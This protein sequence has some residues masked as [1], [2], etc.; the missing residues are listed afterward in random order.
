MTAEEN[1]MAFLKSSEILYT[2][3]NKTTNLLSAIGFSMP[4]TCNHSGFIG[5]ITYDGTK[6]NIEG[7]SF[8]EVF[9][10]GEK[11]SEQY[12]DRDSEGTQ[13]SEGQQEYFKDSKVRDENGNL[14]IMY[15]GTAND[16]TVFNPML[17]GGKMVRKKAMESI[18]LI[19]PVERY[20]IFSGSFNLKHSLCM[21]QVWII[22]NSMTPFSKVRKRD[23]S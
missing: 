12:S 15:H 13:L 9:P 23:N 18:L 20:T 7:K 6:I 19:L 2:E 10:V 21:Q 22:M 1:G 17:Q 11:N 14:K 3:K 8:D 16:F 4:I 5:S